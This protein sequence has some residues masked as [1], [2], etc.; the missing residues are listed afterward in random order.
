MQ[1]I[2]TVLNC[3]DLALKKDVQLLLNPEDDELIDLFECGPA[4]VPSNL[5]SSFDD[6]FFSDIDCEEELF[7]E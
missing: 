6:L 7:T 2:S 4:G 3:G 5:A 1:N